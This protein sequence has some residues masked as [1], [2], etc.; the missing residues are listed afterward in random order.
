MDTPALALAALS[1]G[2]M[3]G[4]NVRIL[5]RVLDISWLMLRQVR[6]QERV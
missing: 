1:S 2:G 5:V 4:V 3:T 6:C